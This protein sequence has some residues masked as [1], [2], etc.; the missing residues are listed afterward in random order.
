VRDVC[1]CVVQ[2]AG[3][4]ASC[5]AAAAPG[6]ETSEADGGTAAEERGRSQGTGGSTGQMSSA[7]C[8]GYIT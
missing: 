5:V 2:R 6:A 4:E 1:T 3:E 7:L 8:F